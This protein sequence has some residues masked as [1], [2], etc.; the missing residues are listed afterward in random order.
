M[1]Y[2]FI[3]LIFIVLMLLSGAGFSQTQYTINVPSNLTEAQIAQLQS[4]ANNMV[5]TDSSS[6]M[7]KSIAEWKEISNIL[8]DSLIATAQKLGITV[9]EFASSGV[10]RLLTIVLLWNY[11]G[12]SLVHLIFGFL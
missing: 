11:L 7:P 5:A 12:E 6:S 3:V 4:S 10:G 1:K 8:S 2:L 9:N